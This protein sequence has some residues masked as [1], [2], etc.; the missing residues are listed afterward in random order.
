LALSAIAQAA[1]PNRIAL[2]RT[3][4]ACVADFKLIGAP[5]PCLQVDLSTG[6]DRGYVVLRPPFGRPDLILAPTRKVVGVEDPWLQS[7][8]APNYFEAAWRALP[9]FHKPGSDPPATDDFALGVNSAFTRSQDQL[10]IHFGCLIPSTKRALSA[11]APTLSV[12]SW[13]RVDE[14]V[15]GVLVWAL[16]T[17]KPALD[18]V[19]PFRLAAE[20]LAGHIKSRAQLMIFVTQIHAEG[21]EF[22]IL[23][24]YAGQ[25]YQLEAEDILDTS[26]PARLSNSN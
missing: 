11:V 21:D 5:F 13:A 4:R 24:S 10:H 22:V 7:P 12:G 26:C 1:S 2:Y 16:R 6:E 20:G 17:G 23:A 9:L 14:V 25:R 15:P 8:N 3:V 19:D 18:G